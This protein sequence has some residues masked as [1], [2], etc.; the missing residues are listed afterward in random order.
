M[1]HTTS[2]DLA[3]FIHNLP[4]RTRLK[5][6]QRR[7]DSAFFADLRR[8]LAA[9]SGVVSVSASPDAASIVVHHSP[10]FQWSTVRLEALGLKLGDVN[11]T[12]TCTCLRCQDRGA[13]E[14]KFGTACEW[15]IGLLLS[16]HPLAQVV[17]W[18]SSGLIRSALDDLT[19]SDATRALSNQPAP[20]A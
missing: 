12:C 9:C 15:I 8:R 19:A 5:V 4:R 16:G 7:R 20:Q 2:G 6:P 14:L 1:R 13:S 10:D 18:A 11:A 3:Y 17:K